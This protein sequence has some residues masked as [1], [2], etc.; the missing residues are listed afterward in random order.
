MHI[1]P[2]KVMV[3]LGTRPEAIKLA[4]VI[5]ELQ[6]YTQDFR[7]TLCATGQHRELFD[8]VARLFRMPLNHKLRLMTSNQSLDDL[9]A[10]LL[11]GISGILKRVRPNLII[12]QG[13]TSTAL[14]GALAGVYHRIKVA[15][16]EAGLRT[17][18]RFAP[19]PE[20]INRRL[21]S[22]MADFHFAP[23]EW[24]ARN[25]IR[26]GIPRARVFVTGNTVLDVFLAVLRRVTKAPP[27]VPEL[28]GVP[29][30]SGKKL[31]L[32]TAHRRESFGLGIINICSALRSLIDLRTDIEIVYPVHPNPNVYGPVHQRLGGIPRIHL[33]PPLE[34]VPFIWLMNK[35][36]LVLTDSGGIQEEMP[37]LRRPVLVMRDKT[38]RPEGLKAGVCK[39]VGTDP[40]I[41]KRTVVRLLDDHRAYKQFSR[42]PSPFGDGKA[43]RRIVQHLRREL[44]GPMR[45]AG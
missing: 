16:V 1:R 21:V 11:V 37:S 10:K 29:L 8:Q 26:E 15:H 39:L 41:I 22:Q 27:R 38:E 36:Y 31:I 34:Y 42:N 13:D 40:E 4:P 45:S 25:L 3:I 35:A 44:V 20:E 7:L 9:T 43:S 24:A 2:L 5:R 30:S 32:V 14:A 17:Q 33:I 18:D 23:T 12:V 19:F 28:N 6:L